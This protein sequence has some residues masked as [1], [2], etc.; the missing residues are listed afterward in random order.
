MKLVNI[1]VPQ[2]GNRWV[3][4]NWVQFIRIQ[5]QPV[6]SHFHYQ[7]ITIKKTSKSNESQIQ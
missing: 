2:V 3:K 6:K 4:S 5:R 7:A 1:R